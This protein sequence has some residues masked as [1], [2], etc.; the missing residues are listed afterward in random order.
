[1]PRR[2]TNKMSMTFSQ[3][4]YRKVA[5]QEKLRPIEMLATLAPIWRRKLELTQLS[6]V[7]RAP[8]PSRLCALK[9]NHHYV[10]GAELVGRSAAVPAEP[11]GGD[12]VSDRGIPIPSLGLV[13]VLS[14][15]AWICAKRT[16]SN[17]S[18]VDC[19]EFFLG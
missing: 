8:E 17:C 15:G 3:L 19:G 16:A 1:M 11:A 13:C 14:G 7:L 10:L 9:H 4:L 6:R 12:P 18:V 2:H 5:E